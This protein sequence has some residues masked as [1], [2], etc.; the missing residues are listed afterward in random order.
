MDIISRNERWNKISKRKCKALKIDTDKI[1]KKSLKRSIKRINHSSESKDEMCRKV[2]NEKAAALVKN[3][4]GEKEECPA[5]E[6]DIGSVDCDD[7]KMLR[8]MQ[9]KAHPDKNRDC[10]KLARKKFQK[11]NSKCVES[12]DESSDSSESEEDDFEDLREKLKKKRKPKTIK[13]ESEHFIK[14]VVEPIN[15]A[16]QELNDEFSK[17]KNKKTRK[18]RK[19]LDDFKQSSDVY[20]WFKFYSKKD[21]KLEDVFEK[22]NEGLN[23]EKDKD[24]EKY[25]GTDTCVFLFP[26]DRERDSDENLLMSLCMPVE[27]NECRVRVCFD[28]V[29]ILEMKV[30]IGEE[31]KRY[32]DTENKSIQRQEINIY[33][34]PIKVLVE[35]NRSRITREN[36]EGDEDKF[37]SFLDEVEDTTDE[38]FFDLVQLYIDVEREGKLNKNLELDITDFW[39]IDKILKPH[40]DGLSKQI[41]NIPYIGSIWKRTSSVSQ[42]LASMVTGSD[43]K[44]VSYLASLSYFRFLVPMFVKTLRVSICLMMT[45]A[46]QEE[47]EIVVDRVFGDILNPRIKD[48]LVFCIKTIYNCFMGFTVDGGLNCVARAVGEAGY[49]LMKNLMDLLRM[50]V[51]YLIKA[52]LNMALRLFGPFGGSMAN[53]T[54]G[55][56]DRLST[57]YPSQVICGLGIDFLGSCSAASLS[58][59]QALTDKEIK[60][61]LDPSNAAFN[62]GILLF[63]LDKIPLRY[64]A[65]PIRW[66]L[67]GILKSMKG[68]YKF[69]DA[70]VFTGPQGAAAVAAKKLILDP[71]SQRIFD[72]FEALLKDLDL[73][74][75]RN[76][77]SKD[78]F[79][80]VFARMTEFMYRYH[81]FLIWTL[82]I[83]EWFKIFSCAFKNRV[84]PVVRELVMK[85]PGLDEYI[86]LENQFPIAA[87]GGPV[88]CC[89]RDFVS[90]MKLNRADNIKGGLSQK[91]KIFFGVWWS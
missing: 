84:Y 48:F 88:G 77:S 20:D 61:Y 4:K 64:F 23:K 90:S 14:N 34:N 42:K 2:A 49:G 55:I 71:Y 8:E 76:E 27:E 67:G 39:F 78:Y 30:K 52:L 73:F 50:G 12:S 32:Y 70:A 24:Y 87:Q 81:S 31:K 29:K 89:L 33:Q 85:I 13:E 38:I 58:Y 11:L 69:A 43:S 28:P 35:K 46:T 25:F 36:F 53:F 63:F 86:D 15:M 47:I 10:E 60:D 56:L 68:G 65:N 21:I 1:D 17:N 66:I 91:Y 75:K 82:E 7:R 41:G 45:D 59:N 3:M 19:F 40:L 9:R 79:I 83:W 5:K 16:S 26:E 51:L 37:D 80:H 74:L 54:E 18:Q 22:L 44:S 6:V 57:I 72:Y 62:I